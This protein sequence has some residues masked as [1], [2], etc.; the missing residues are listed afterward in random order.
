MTVDFFLLVTAAAEFDFSIAS[1]LACAGRRKKTKKIKRRGEIFFM[2][3]RGP[4]GFFS[5]KAQD[6]ICEN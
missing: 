6:R 4:T 2:V 1:T 5:R 3:T